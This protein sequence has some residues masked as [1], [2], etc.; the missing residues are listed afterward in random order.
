MS[1]TGESVMNKWQWRGIVSVFFA[2]SLVMVLSAGTAQA[3]CDP[4]DP[5]C[6]PPP[7]TTACSP[8]YWKNH[9]DEFNEFC[10]AAAA[11][12]LTEELDSCPELLT[13]LTCKGSDAS[14]LRSVAA[15]LMN[16][17]SGCEE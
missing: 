8:G 6:E 16:T 7:K 5:K 1:T 9:L 11:L 14:C 12:A 13:A 15:A 17:V 3:Q 4:K 10:G 2:L